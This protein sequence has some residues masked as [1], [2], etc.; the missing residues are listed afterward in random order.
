MSIGT[1]AALVSTFA[2]GLLLG[3]TAPAHAQ[4]RLCDPGAEDCRTILINLIRNE[5]VGI[6]VGFWFMEDA[7]YTNELI[8]KFNAGVPVRVLVDPRANGSYSLNAER[9]AELETARIPMR[10]RIASGI[11]HYKMMLFAG[12]NTVEFSGANYSSDAWRPSGDPYTNY[13]DE[14]IYFTSDPSVVNSFRTKFDDLWTNTST[15]ANYANISGP[16]LRHY[17]LY[18]K[19]PE[20]NFPPTESY[21]SR[22]TGRYGKETEKIDV[23][24]Y[25][26]TDRRHTDAIIA[27]RGRGVPVRLITEPE[28]YRDENRLWHSWNVDRLYMAGVQIKH[29]AHAGLN[30]QKSVLLYGLGL[31]IFGSSNWTSPSS[32]SQEEHNYFTAKP[33]IFNWLVDQFERK[34]NNSA[35]VIE[36]VDFVPLP[37]DAA[38]TPSPAHLAA[39]AGTSVTLSWFGGPWAHKYDVYFGTSPAPPLVAADLELGPSE[40]SK[41]MQS[42]AVPTALTAG[43]TYYWRIVSKTMANMSKSSAVW[44]FTTAGSAPPPP[45]GGSA[46][47][48]DVVLHAGT[49]TVTAGT[50]APVADTT[51]AGGFRM[52]QPNAGAAKVTTAAAA[53]AHYFEMT[54]TAEA[55][56]PYRLWMRGR[57]LSNSYNNDSVFVQFSDSVTSGG[58]ATWRIG[59]G[60]ATEVNLEDCS[61]CGLSGWGWQDNGWGTGV[62]GPLVYFAS[63]GTHT[64]RVQTREDGFQID[65]IVLSQGPFLSMSPGALKNDTLI[66][67]AQDGSG[68]GSPPP[69][70]PPPPAETGEVVLYASEAPVAMGTWGVNKDS[71]AAGGFSMRQ[72]NAGAPKVEV[73]AAAPTDYFEMTFTAEAGVPY[74]LWVR[75]KAQNNSWKN[76]SVFAQFS[77]SVTGA[78]SATYRIGTTSAT[79]INIEDC[80]GCGLAGWGWQDNG[81]GEGVLGPVIYF[82]SSGPQTIRIQSRED[83]LA[84]DQIVLSP[85]TW[86]STSPGALKSDTTILPR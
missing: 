10:K 65:Q 55:G 41:Q 36:N 70:P 56:K 24:M 13:T 5:N 51:A 8:K 46:G 79:E 52:G 57:A 3:S 16:L 86:L 18:T 17:D 31:S 35:G 23:V 76:D 37:P 22:A 42:Y 69:P 49:A 61:G 7:R 53:P 12:Q 71:S 68:G 15:Y 44:S 82:A 32:N 84:I 48:G 2:I 30:H 14:V 62:L 85:R 78:G 19:D 27:A 60:S 39:D 4:D 72:P 45:P 58:A 73:A 11:L 9:L 66:L 34:W 83:G 25:R 63:G 28:Q 64:I 1:R 20:L 74:R 29:R 77:G 54:F 26:I 38:K 21:S 59:T 67:A 50:W 81:W 40:N 6:D 33:E 75:G 80:S 47:P 43:T